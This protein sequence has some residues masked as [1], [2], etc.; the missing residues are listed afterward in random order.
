MLLQA[1]LSCC[2]V[3]H[4]LQRNAESRNIQ[5]NRP[6]SHNENFIDDFEP[7]RFGTPT[8]TMTGGFAVA[9]DEAC[10]TPYEDWWGGMG[11]GSDSEWIPF[12]SAG[13]RCLGVNEIDSS[14]LAALQCDVWNANSNSSSN[15]SLNE[16]SSY[17]CG[18]QATSHHYRPIQQCKSESVKSN[19]HFNLVSQ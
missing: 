9:A 16:N 7:P 12:N 3:C 8:R 15:R 10:V 4:S 6:Y 14:S 5:V 1:L 17:A 19:I 11:E 18:N 2:F 13:C